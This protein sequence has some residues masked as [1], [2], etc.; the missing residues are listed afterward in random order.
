MHNLLEEA[1]KAVDMCMSPE[2]WA[3]AGGMDRYIV[4]SSTRRFATSDLS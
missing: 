4:S 2:A 3:E 1:T